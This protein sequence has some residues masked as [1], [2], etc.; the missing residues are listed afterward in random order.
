MENW[1]VPCIYWDFLQ[2][3]LSFAETDLVNLNLS[4]NYLLELSLP[5]VGDDLIQQC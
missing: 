3:I 2:I 5:L 4:L 1:R